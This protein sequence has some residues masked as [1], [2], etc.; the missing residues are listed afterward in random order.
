MP[1]SHFIENMALL[2]VSSDGFVFV[3]AHHTNYFDLQRT[4]THLRSDKLRGLVAL[5]T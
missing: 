5:G 2:S 4:L 3:D 1:E